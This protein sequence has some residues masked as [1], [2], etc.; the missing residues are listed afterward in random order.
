MMGEE[1]C[2]TTVFEYMAEAVPVF[3]EVGE[4]KAHYSKVNM[5]DRE[6]DMMYRLLARVY[7]A[8]A[9]VH[10]AKW[11]RGWNLQMGGAAMLLVDTMVCPIPP[12]VGPDPVVP[13]G[14]GHEKWCPTL[15]P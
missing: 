2:G 7:L 6:I 14:D 5:C 11:P 8:R 9:H 15:Q 3:R 1:S 12:T 4:T 13:M 10:T